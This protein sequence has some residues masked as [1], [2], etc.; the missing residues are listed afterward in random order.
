MLL[1]LLLLLLSRGRLALRG[2]EA[3][4]R[5][6]DS[7]VMLAK[8]PLALGSVCKRGRTPTDQSPVWQSPCIPYGMLAL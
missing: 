7:I 5:R 3:G 4:V 2:R 6:L 8:V 1:L